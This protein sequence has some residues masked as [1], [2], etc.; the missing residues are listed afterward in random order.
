MTKHGIKLQKYSKA[1][2]NGKY[3]LVN[4]FEKFGNTVLTLFW[5]RFEDIEAKLEQMA[6]FISNN[7]NNFIPIYAKLTHIITTKKK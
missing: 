6:W 1:N 3:S 4:I 2:K 7:G 5:Q